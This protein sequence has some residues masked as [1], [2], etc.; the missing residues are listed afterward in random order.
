[1]GPQEHNPSGWKKKKQQLCHRSEL[2]GRLKTARCC[3]HAE[4]L[5]V[6]HSCYTYS[7]RQLHSIK[8]QLSV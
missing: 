3:Q 4:K 1:M 6:T 7:T 5:G 8:N 2:P